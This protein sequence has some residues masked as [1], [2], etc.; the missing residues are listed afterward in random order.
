M[1]FPR[2]GWVGKNLGGIVMTSAFVLS[3]VKTIHTMG[4]EIVKRSAIRR[5]QDKPVLS[6]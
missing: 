5:V 2:V 1:K 4:K 3:D 6:V